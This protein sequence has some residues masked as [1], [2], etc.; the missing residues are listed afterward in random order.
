MLLGTVSFRQGKVLSFELKIQILLVVGQTFLTFTIIIMKNLS[1]GSPMLGPV[2]GASNQKRISK[3]LIN[4][5][6]YAFDLNRNHDNR[7]YNNRLQIFYP[8]LQKYGRS[9]QDG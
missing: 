8:R 7:A 5:K 3:V 6:N 2:E 9:L 1:V 4:A